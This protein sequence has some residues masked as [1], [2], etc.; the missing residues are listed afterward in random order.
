MI[1]HLPRNSMDIDWGILGY[2]PFSDPA[3]CSVLY[4]ND[5]D[6]EDEDNAIL[7]QRLLNFVIVVNK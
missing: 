5:K 7:L 6:K 2:P 4:N 1:Y 3:D